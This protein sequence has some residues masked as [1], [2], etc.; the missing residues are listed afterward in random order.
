MRFKVKEKINNKVNSLIKEKK[1]YK[2]RTC[3]V[4]QHNGVGDMINMVGAIRYLTL[5]YDKV[6]IPT[7]EVNYEK[8]TKLYRDDDTVVIVNNKPLNYSPGLWKYYSTK[9]IDNKAERLVHIQVN[10]EEA[11]T[12][13]KNTYGDIY[14]CGQHKVGYTDSE[15]KC[16]P[17]N[18]YDDMKIPRNVFWTHYKINIP[19]ESIK[20]YNQISGYKIVFICAHYAHGIAFNMNK[21]LEYLHIDPGQYLII[22]PQQN[23]Y[24]DPTSKKYIIAQSLMNKEIFDYISIIENSDYIIVSDSSFFCMAIHIPIKTDN[25][26]Y[27]S[28]DWNGN[29][30]NYKYIWDDISYK[31]FSLREFKCLN[32]YINDM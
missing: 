15:S 17:F 3:M 19:D 7:D 27:I 25:A 4:V 6:Y 1:G 5:I 13:M 22:N 29:R 2:P 10:A 12:N 24:N 9:H 31:T 14:L 26:Y 8:I 21:V 23:Y 16:L 18:F 32:S 11:Y 30:H 28:R 20:L